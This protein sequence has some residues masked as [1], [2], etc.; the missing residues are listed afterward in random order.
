[1]PSFILSGAPFFHHRGKKLGAIRAD[2]ELVRSFLPGR[3]LGI[4]V[5]RAGR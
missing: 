1:V 3:A 2:T 4:E 5:E